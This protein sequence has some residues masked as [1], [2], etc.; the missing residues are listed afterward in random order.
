MS[1]GLGVRINMLATTKSPFPKNDS[2]QDWMSAGRLETESEGS[3]KYHLLF[4]HEGTKTRSARRGKI[5]ASE[6]LCYS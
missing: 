4:Y 1:R 2:L 3:E 5:I 6:N